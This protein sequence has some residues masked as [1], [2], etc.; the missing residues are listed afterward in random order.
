MKCLVRFIRL[1]PWIDL[2]GWSITYFLFIHLLIFDI[3]RCA[4]VINFGDFFFQ[5]ISSLYWY[6]GLM[7]FGI[8]LIVH[9]RD[10]AYVFLIVELKQILR[11]LGLNHKHWHRLIWHFWNNRTNNRG[12]Y[13]SDQNRSSPF[14][15]MLS[16]LRTLAVGHSG[17]IN[18]GLYLLRIKNRTIKRFSFLQAWDGIEHTRAAH[19]AMSAG[20]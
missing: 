12:E 17:R 2:Y 6:S 7:C 11:T 18:Y 1:S 5:C 20:Q 9:W 15:Q 14:P 4:L 10:N 3:L 8:F 19:L 13:V 16:V